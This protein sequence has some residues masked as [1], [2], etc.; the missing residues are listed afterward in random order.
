MMD[1]PLSPSSPMLTPPIPAVKRRGR[2]G[3]RSRSDKKLPVPADNYIPHYHEE[4]LQEA[5]ATYLDAMSK[6]GKKFIWFHPPN[7][8]KRHIRTAAKLKKQGTKRGPA[9]CIL[10]CAGGRVI[11]IELKRDASLSPM[12]IEWKDT[13]ARLGHVTYVVKEKTPSDAVNSVEKILRQERL[14]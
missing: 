7:G 12:Q 14:M 2:A 9:D 10:F 4:H 5:V 11:S 1:F 13:L 6:H 8:G 3:T